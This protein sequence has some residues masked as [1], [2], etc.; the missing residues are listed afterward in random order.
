M[1]TGGG[2]DC[3]CKKS[4]G[5]IESETTSNEIPFLLSVQLTDISQTRWEQFYREGI[6]KG[7]S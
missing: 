1:P 6:G 2:D 3:T 7:E 4:M 5:L